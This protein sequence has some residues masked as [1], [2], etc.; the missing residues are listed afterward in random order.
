[1][2]LN[3]H[4]GVIASLALSLIGII[5]SAKSRDKKDNLLRIK[6]SR[7]PSSWV[8]VLIVGIIL[9]VGFIL[10]V[11]TILALMLCSLIYFLIENKFYVKKDHWK[12]VI[13]NGSTHTLK[14]WPI[15]VIVGFNSALMLPEYKQ[16]DNVIEIKNGNYTDIT[17]IVISACIIAP[18]I[19]ELIFRG[20]LYPL[21]K[22]GIGVF[23]GCVI[24]SLTFSFVHY[25][26]LS[27]PVL[28][29]FSCS[30]TYVYEKN[31]NIV[32]PMISHSIFN[33]I[34]IILMILAS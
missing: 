9:I 27:F 5:L 19:E 6:L 14:V 21:L 29:V 4:I 22:K 8:L 3:L 25:N 28:F 12:T 13:I 26:I 20:M 2:P 15:I 1:L 30:L 17:L 7:S 18:I 32:V 34:M 16:Q 33:C 31:N 11:N 24:S 23:W 10:K